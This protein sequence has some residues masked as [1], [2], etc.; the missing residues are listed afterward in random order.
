M[1]LGP[2]TGKLHPDLPHSRVT[3]PQRRG[4]KCD[5][6]HCS[7]FRR[8]HRGN[9][10]GREWGRVLKPRRPGSEKKTIGTFYSFSLP[11]RLIRE[12]QAMREMA[13]QCLPATCLGKHSCLECAENSENSAMKQI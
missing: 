2:S 5:T 4:G 10:W 8:A 9:L 6:Q 1:G 7:V 11:H 13:I 3:S 12:W